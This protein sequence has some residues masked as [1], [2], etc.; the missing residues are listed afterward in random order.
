MLF[1]GTQIVMTGMLASPLDDAYIHL[2]YAKQIAKGAYFQYQDGA[3]I[4]SGETSFLY[5]HLLALGC[6]LGF[7]GTGLLAWAQI[8]AFVC[9][10]AIFYLLIQIGDNLS[11]PRAGWGAAVLVFCS[12]C[13]A[14]AFWSGMEIALFTALL[15]FVC[16][17]ITCPVF[18]A[19]C[20]WYALGLLC[21][22]RPEG[23]ICAFVILMISVLSIFISSESFLFP[24]KT[25]DLH[26]SFI[27]RLKQFRMMHSSFMFFLFSIIG[28]PLFFYFSL[29][30]VSGNS[31]LAKS[32][33]Y[34]PILTSF[35]K[36]MEF[37][38]NVGSI[39]L[40]FMGHPAATPHIGEYLM[41]GTL[42][43]AVIGVI[44]LFLS[45]SLSQKW[46]TA[47]AGLSLTT[48]IFAVATL[49]VWPLHNYRY[50]LPYFPLLFLFGI[51]GLETLFSWIKFQTLLPV[52]TLLLIA[53]L[54]Q[55]S[56]FPA[57]AGRFAKNAAS[58]YEKQIQTSRWI[59][60]YLPSDRPIAIN[61]AGALAYY[62]ALKIYDLVGLVTNDTT[63]AYRMGEG[64]LY[65]S[66]EH[67]S[68]TERP[69]YAVVFPSWFQESAITYDIF[70]KPLVS[71][72]DPFDRTFGKTVYHINWS[73]AGMENQPRQATMKP[74]WIVKDSLDI[75]D[76][77][78]EADHQY[79]FQVH[80]N[81]FPRI[82]VP[83]RRN[84]GYHEEIDEL[85]PDIENE[86]E[87]LIPILR[88]QGILNQ[89]DIV[90]AGRRID[91]EEQFTLGNLTAGKETYLIIRTC[92]GMGERY[93]FAYRMGVFV[94]NIYLGEWNV[95]GTS[96]NWY[97]SIFTITGEAVKTDS[98]RIRIKNMRTQNYPYYASYYYWICQENEDA[99]P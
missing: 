60:R 43:F 1:I 2:Q 57:W 38:S 96:W 10:A 17:L 73:Y 77:R 14:W 3:P 62:G 13:L 85:W 99:Q 29:G 88:Q 58:I 42:L 82:P 69:H 41:P 22:C 52:T 27:S 49:E 34:S 74:N 81:R 66:L 56:Y 71:F 36:G 84:F 51:I 39:G 44:G 11:H 9:L 93:T 30:R 16:Y 24:F 64:G 20:L 21:L 4:T 37:F 53:I 95:E 48:L 28:P 5:A 25:N 80:H 50:L 98:L 15:L 72:P 45:R 55:T 91:G 67:L 86:Q 65:E 92:Y 47:V 83:F 68:E 33:L 40:F 7:H 87:E 61:D 8:I 59:S 35:E 76:L 70:Y 19:K 46:F 12:G 78:S 18:S 79:T 32:L 54:L 63:L 94:D 6:L 23:M 97:E 75:A 90:D 89:F 31:L 26:H